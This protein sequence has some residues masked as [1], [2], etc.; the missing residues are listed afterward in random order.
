MKYH[1]SGR[2]R[3]V[4]LVF[5]A[6]LG[7]AGVAL[8]EAMPPARPTLAPPITAPTLDLLARIRQAGV[9]RVGTTGDYDPFSFLDPQGRFQG[10]DADAAHRLARAIGPNVQVRFVKTS[11]PTMTADLLA[12][13]FDIAMSGVSRNSNRSSSG[14][15]SR[16]YLIDAK[17]ALIRTA[18][19]AKYRTLLDLDRGEVTVLVNPG[20]TNQQFVQTRLKQA[21]TVVVQDNLAIPRMVAEGKGDVMFTDGVEA[22]LCAKRD[23]RLCLALTDPPLMKVEKVYYLPRGHA[24]LLDVV[25]AWIGTMQTDGLYARLL[26]KYVGE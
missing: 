26:A 5:A 25:N 10:I 8:Q 18:D 15:L 20:G 14:E 17:V 1:L 9:L 3:L 19:R 24:A 11:W 22:R 7:M 21:R 23:P 6:L 16:S 2:A 13:R 12:D 4:L